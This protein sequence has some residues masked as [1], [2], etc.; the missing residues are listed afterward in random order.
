[1]QNKRYYYTDPLIAA[2]M[3]KYFDFMIYTSFGRNGNGKR[4]QSVN[5]LALH[6]NNYHDTMKFYIHPDSLHLL[7]PKIGDLCEKKVTHSYCHYCGWDS[8]FYADS[9]DSIELYGKGAKIIERQGKPF[10]WPEEEA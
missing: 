8:L 1:M 2:Y 7:E 6:A 3:A 9:N 10:M 5:S 4:K